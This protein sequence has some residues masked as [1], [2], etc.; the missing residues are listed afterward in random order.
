MFGLKASTQL[1]VE[2]GGVDVGSLESAEQDG[3][4]GGSPI[5]IR[6]AVQKLEIKYGSGLQVQFGVAPGAS[7]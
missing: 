6:A 7:C 5:E 2:V 3:S 1:P 4:I